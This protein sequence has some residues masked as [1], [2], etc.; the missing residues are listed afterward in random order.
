MIGLVSAIGALGGVFINVAFR[1]SF[2]VTKSGTTAVVAFLVFYA[3]CFV[4]TWVVYLRPASERTTSPE[5][6]TVRV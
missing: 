5:L 2:L 6:A 3:L 1:Q 4:V